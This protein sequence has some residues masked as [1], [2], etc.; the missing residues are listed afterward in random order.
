[1]KTSAITQ[2]MHSQIIQKPSVNT[3]K[4]TL[5]L[6]SVAGTVRKFAMPIFFTLVLSNIPGAEAGPMAYAACTTLCLGFATPVFA[7]L[8]ITGCLPALAALTP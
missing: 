1:M 3:G 7:P 8:C 2:S 4:Y 5:S 6:P